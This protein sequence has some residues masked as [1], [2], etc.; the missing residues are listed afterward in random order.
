MNTCHTAMAGTGSM[1]IAAA[2]RVSGSIV[3]EAIAGRERKETLS[4]GH[5][6]GVMHVRV[7]A[8]EADTDAGVGFETLGFG[9]TARKIM[10]GTV[11]VPTSDNY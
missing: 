10:D 8:R 11:Y 3:N 4:M 6:S 7:I 2:S 9:R 1:C 5:P